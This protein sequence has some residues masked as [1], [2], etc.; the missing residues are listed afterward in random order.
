MSKYVCLYATLLLLFSVGLAVSLVATSGSEPATI[1]IGSYATYAGSTV[2][3]PVE[4]LNATEIA[5]GSANISFNPS[6]VNVQEVLPGDFGAPTANINNTAGFVSIAKSTATAIGKDPAE[7]ASIRFKGISKGITS[8]NFTSAW[9]NY[10]NGTGFTPETADGNITVFA[11]P[12]PFFIYGYVFYENGSKCHNPGVNVTNLNASNEWQAKTCA[13]YN[14]YQF[15]LNTTNINAGDVLEFNVMDGT[16]FNTSSYTVTQ[17]EIDN[18]GLFG[19]NLML[20]TPTPTPTPTPGP[21]PVGVPEFNA[22]GLVALIGLLSV[23][24]AVT[25]VGSKRK[26]R[27]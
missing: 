3:V 22:L 12:T 25:T 21:G 1:S 11:P 6:I 18:G 8:L 4:I 23:L 9:L 10:E 24:L 14:Y 13:G 5:G 7:L 19:F 26:R 20:P 27:E 16:Q 17:D 15:I 2:T